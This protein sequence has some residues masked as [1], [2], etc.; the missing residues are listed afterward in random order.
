[1][2]R[3]IFWVL[4]LAILLAG[5]SGFLITTADTKDDMRME[6]PSDLSDMRPALKL[7]CAN[8][9]SCHSHKLYPD[10]YFVEDRS[11]EL[12][13]WTREYFPGN[14]LFYVVVY[15]PHEKTWD[16]LGFEHLYGIWTA[17]IYLGSGDWYQVPVESN[18]V[19]LG[20]AGENWGVVVS[21]TSDSSFEYKVIPD[22]W[23]R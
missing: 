22:Y 8:V 1:M 21:A 4:A 11:E 9:V 20:Y 10:K 2:D 18:S 23:R 17:G 3:R 12:Y 13:I 6:Y 16:G 5:C 19:A 14:F 7:N 15:R